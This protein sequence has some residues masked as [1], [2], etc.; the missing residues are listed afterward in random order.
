MTIINGKN[1]KK[2]KNIIHLMRSSSG[3]DFMLDALSTAN[4]AAKKT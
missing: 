2:N 4:A 1:M 3:I